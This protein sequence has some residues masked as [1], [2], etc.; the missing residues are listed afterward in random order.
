MIYRSFIM[1]LVL[2]RV[3]IRVRFWKYSN[4]YSNLKK[5]KNIENDAV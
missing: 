2:L 4:K 1:I 5:K 3:Q